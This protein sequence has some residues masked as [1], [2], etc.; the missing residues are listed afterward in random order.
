MVYNIESYYVNEDFATE[1][2]VEFQENL[3]TGDRAMIY[4]QLRNL[5]G[6][7]AAYFMSQNY[8][9]ELPYKILSQQK[10]IIT[11]SNF[12]NLMSGATSALDIVLSERPD[13]RLRR[14]K[15]VILLDACFGSELGVFYLDAPSFMDATF[16]YTDDAL[17]KKFEYFGIISDNEYFRDYDPKSGLQGLKPC[18]GMPW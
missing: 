16:V 17:T 10:M 13:I 2:L 9:V 1:L 6:Q 4:Y 3:T 8:Y 7:T 11:G 15:G 5:N 14:K 12:Q 18:E